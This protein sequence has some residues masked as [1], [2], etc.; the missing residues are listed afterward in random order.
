[1][2]TFTIG[3]AYRKDTRWPLEYGYGER[4]DAD[5]L[6]LVVHTTNGKKGSSFAGECRFLRDS[7]AVSCG[8]VVGK[9]GQIE[10][11]LPDELCGWHAGG[12]YGPFG[13][14]TSIG[15][16]CHHAVGEAW[17]D[18]QFAALTWLCGVLISRWNIPKVNIETHRKIALPKGRK[19]DPSDWSDKNF[20]AWR[21]GLYNASFADRSVIGVAPSITL[22]TF[23]AA[24][25]DH[26]APLSS[27]E[28][29]RVYDLCRWVEIDPNF[30]LHLW[31][32]E[33]GSPLGGSVLQ[34]QT[35]CPINIKTFRW[36]GRDSVAYN[37][38]EWATYESFQL[39]SFESLIHLKQVHGADGRHTVRSIVP[40]HAPRRD[41]NDPERIISAILEGMRWTE[42]NR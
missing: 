17:T 29:G 6:S 33:S 35:H 41:G 12:T 39:G 32:V 20:Y 18:K 5:I 26:H 42:T 10:Q 40:V 16:E 38:S 19:V 34:Q 27:T 22:T 1:M 24:L 21:D 9:A 23:V 36:D 15:I 3:Q 37:G 7:D 13:N 8:Y 25:K 4:N 28:M 30:F 11:L 14:A 31:M 2:T